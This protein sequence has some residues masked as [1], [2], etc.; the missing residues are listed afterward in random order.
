M[1]DCPGF[2]QILV[3]QNVDFFTGV[4]DSSLKDICA[5]ITDHAPAGRHVIAANEGNA[6]ALATGHYLATGRPALVYMQNSGQGNAAN[7]LI[8]LAD[9][10]VYG[11][12]MLLLIGWRGEPGVKDEPQH[13]KQG[14]ITL[15]LLETMGIPCRILPDNVQDARSCVKELLAQGVESGGPVA[16]VARKGTFGPYVPQDAATDDA[17][18]SREEAIRHIV[19]RLGDTDIVVSTTGKI[20]RELYEIREALSQGHAR[21]FLT[22]GSMGHASQI[23]M[24]IALEKTSRQVFCLDGDGAVIMHM[25]AMAI[26]GSQ[27][28]K[29][30]KHIVL[31][32]GAHDSVGGQP[33]VGFAVSLT[34]IARACGYASVWLARTQAELEEA[35][36]LLHMADGPALLDV[37]V[38]K[39]ARPDLGRPKTAPGE[40]RCHFMEFLAQ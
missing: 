27:K 21:D 18:L 4:P 11:I 25:G 6:V 29:N 1:L 20:S 13:R 34:E 31:N 36:E 28:L 33:T 9:P 39:G 19:D 8:S 10:D 35:L 16:L 26:I 23:A 2:H 12:P 22:V 3:E 14:K 7:P 40:N 17:S 32:N 24:G 37:R 15:A 38:M 5:Y 30:L